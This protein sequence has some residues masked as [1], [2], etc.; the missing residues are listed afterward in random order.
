MKIK[1]QSELTMS[2]SVF[3]TLIVIIVIGFYL[4]KPPKVVP[5]DASLDAFSAERAIKYLPK[6]TAAPHPIGT[7]EHLEVRDYIMDEMKKLGIEPE[8]QIADVFFPYKYGAARVENIIVKVSGTHNS[9]AI[10]VMGHYDSVEDSYG[11]NDNGSTVITM[12]E[13]IRVLLTI[14]TFR[15]D[16]I[17]LFTDGEEIGLYG[18][19]AFVDQHP[20]AKDVGLVLN[21]DAGGSKGQSSMIETSSNNKWI[22]SEF[23]KAVPYPMANSGSNE[24]FQY[25]PMGTDFTAFKNSGYKG[26]N[27]AYADDQFDIHSYG[28]NYDNISLESIQHHGSYATS[29]VKHFGNINFN[30]ST[31]GNAVYFN[32]IGYGFVYY[33]YSW[34]LP[35]VILTSL[36]LILILIIGVK[37]NIIRTINIFK[38]FIASIIHL[39]IAPAVITCIYFILVKYYPD[40][41]TRLLA[42]N[43]KII[44]LGFV[45]IAIAISFIYYNLLFRGIRLW[46]VIVFTILMLILLYWS[47]RISIATSLAIIMISAFIYLLFR[48][49]T[50]VWE[51]TIGSFITWAIIMVITSIMMKGLSYVFT[52]TL[53][54][55]LIPI[56][57]F[58]SKK[59]QLKYS[60]LSI[61][62][63][64]I[65]ATPVLIWFSYST[66]MFQNAMGLRFAGLSI[67]FTVL[68]LSLLIP[69]IEIITKIKP[70]LI[71]TLT[72]VFGI[73]FLLKGSIN[74]SY[75]ERYKKQ[76]S[77]IYATNVDK[78]ET[79]WTSYEKTVDEWTSNFLTKNPEIEQLTNV[80]PFRSGKH[81]K[82]TVTTEPLPSPIIT[83][84][85]D[86]IGDD[87]RYLKLHLESQRNANQF[88]IQMKSDSK[89]VRASINN[90]ELK[91]IHPFRMTEWYLIHY[92]TLTPEGIDLELKFENENNIEICLTDISYGLPDFL[93]ATQKQRPE[94]MMPSRDRTVATKLFFFKKYF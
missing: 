38:G 32:T 75:S 30:N 34:V 45:G 71:S 26:F 56:G 58:L 77:L 20:L 12:L 41:D 19:K 82:N 13:T 65:C 39:V 48:K 11:A 47:N 59:N 10:L 9:K 64:I 94:Y 91:E 3:I 79:F 68:C 17:F 8:L 37:R 5:A 49:K 44:L 80:F 15:N 18:A 14:E 51:L 25:M 84:I 57:L 66:L 86:S 88:R 29:L 42:Y 89:N 28:D 67:I 31:K 90:S 23:A 40:S 50:N 36:L 61:F 7:T 35:L 81:L 78:N 27:F 21:F 24:V 73:F 55:S 16:V 93:S 53:L 72:L 43:N 92:Y 87:Y 74:L 69:H 46:H 85:N 33:S 83:V 60:A 63:F 22:I 2:L 52:W 1:H 62:L 70:W 54:F 6:I 4:N 76:N